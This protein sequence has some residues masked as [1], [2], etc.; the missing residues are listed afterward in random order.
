MPA[1]IKG[2]IVIA[3]TKL[4][5]VLYKKSRQELGEFF[6][7]PVPL[8][9]FVSRRREFRYLQDHYMKFGSLPDFGLFRT[10]F[11]QFQ[12]LKANADPESYLHEIREHA[13]HLAA[14]DF[15]DHLG[16]LLNT[17]DRNPRKIEKILREHMASLEEMRESGQSDVLYTKNGLHRVSEYWDLR[18]KGGSAGIPTGWAGIDATL[19]GFCKGQLI[20]LVASIYKG[21]SWCLAYLAHNAWKSGAVPMI[22]SKEMTTDE[23]AKRLD[24]IAARISF[25]RLRSRTLK[26]KEMRRWKEWLG[27][28]K[29]PPIYLVGDDASDE[30]GPLALRAKIESKNPKPTI[31]FVDGAYLMEDNRG[32]MSM[33]EKQYRLSR[34][35]KRLAK[36][37]NLPIVVTLQFSGEADKQ[38]F[39]TLNNVA[40]SRSW[41][42]DSDVML[43]LRGDGDPQSKFRTVVVLKCRQGGSAQELINFDLD[44]M[45]F[46]VAAA[47]AELEIVESAGE[48]LL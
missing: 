13:Q 24:A 5:C 4:I 37:M 39:G 44:K 20:S 43:E 10:R 17:E 23:F 27:K 45:N 41:S 1:K 22:V 2:I 18:S 47:G 29:E 3:E 12:K 26:K 48:E 42:M 31:L 7:R 25:T 33:V 35:L 30:G 19:D 8:R 9:I 11:P 14:Q 28:D 6:R 38:G 46:S 16:D 40:W 32:T 34:E 21:K 15:H 36:V